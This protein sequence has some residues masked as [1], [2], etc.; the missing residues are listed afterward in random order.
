SGLSNYAITYQSGTYDITP[1]ALAI[2]ALNQTG[3]YG[4]NPAL[5]KTDFKTSGLVNN[6]AV[7]GVS[8]STTATNLSNTGSYALTASNARGS[9]LSNYAIT[10]QS[11][12]YDI[13]RITTIPIFWPVASLNGNTPPAS[14]P[15]NLTIT[16]IEQ[17]PSLTLVN[18]YN[19]LPL[20]DSTANS[21]APNTYQIVLPGTSYTNHLKDT[22]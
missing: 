11:G 9:G 1:A 22:F 21:A 7:S 19:P 20:P 17:S 10:Y 2:T 5:N 3:I 15:A 6:D 13:T 12:T 4:Q 16:S 14:G 18:N 8:L